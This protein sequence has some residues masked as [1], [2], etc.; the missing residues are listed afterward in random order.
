MMVLLLVFD[1]WGLRKIKKEHD[2]RKEEA[3]RE[4]AMKVKRRRS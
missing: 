2:Q 4:E 1:L 3:E